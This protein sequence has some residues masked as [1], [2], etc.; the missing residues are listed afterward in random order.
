MTHSTAMV[1]VTSF[2]Y[3]D[4]HIRESVILSLFW[5]HFNSSDDHTN[6]TASMHGSDCD[7]EPKDTDEVRKSCRGH[8]TQSDNGVK[9]SP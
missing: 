1:C 9:Y 6:S 8:V 5:K 4:V 2:F 7:V 3:C